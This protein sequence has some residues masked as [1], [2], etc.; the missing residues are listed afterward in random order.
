MSFVIPVLPRSS[1]TRTLRMR[2]PTVKYM[3]LIIGSQDADPVKDV[4][5]QGL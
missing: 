4:E 5:D 3:L 2:R 1:G